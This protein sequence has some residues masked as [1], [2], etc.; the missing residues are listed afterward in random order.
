ML[1]MNWMQRYF[2]PGILKMSGENAQELIY[3]G[4]L[5]PTS[6]ALFQRPRDDQSKKFNPAVN[7]I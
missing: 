7:K 2:Q 3:L 4:H 1:R 5:N 6:D